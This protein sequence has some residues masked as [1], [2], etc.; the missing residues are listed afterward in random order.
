MKKTNIIL[1][2]ISLLSAIGGLLAFK[3]QQRFNGVLFCYTTIGRLSAQGDPFYDAVLTTRY[4]LIDPVKT[5]FCTIPA[6][7]TNYRPMK[8]KPLL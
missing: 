7:N 1:S 4:T 3:A 6:A 8:V 5:L 2:A